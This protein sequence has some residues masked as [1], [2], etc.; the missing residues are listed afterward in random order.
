MG[1]RRPHPAGQRTAAPDIKTF[2]ANEEPMSSRNKSG[3]TI[4][5]AKLHR[6]RVTRDL[7][8][9]PRLLALLDAGRT[10]PLTVVVAPA[11]FGKSTLVSSWIAELVEGRRQGINL[12][13]AIWLSL[14]E[15][16]S[17]PTIFLRYFISGLRTIFPGAA[18]KTLKLLT[19]S[20][21]PHSLLA[22]TLSNEI[23]SLPSSFFIILDDAHTL[24]SP[25]V[26]DILSIWLQHWP[27]HMHLVL[28]SRLNP[29]LPLTT[30]RA[31]DQVVEIRPRDLRFTA[32]ETAEYL[33]QTL[34]SSVDESAL[35]AIHQ[36]MEGWIT[37]LKLATFSPDMQDNFAG[38]PQAVI[39]GDV[40]I[41]D[42]LIEEVLLQQPAAIQRFLLTISINRQF[43]ESLCAALLGDQDP[44][45]DVSE[46]LAYLEANE[47]FL[48]DMDNRREWYRLHQM[49][50]DLLRRKLQYEMGEKALAELHSRAARWY[51]AHD[52]LDQA[53]YHALKGQD[54]VLA[55]QIMQ[56]GICDVLNETDRPKLER[57]LHMLP[58]EIIAQQP[59]LMVM[60]GWDHALRWEMALA[61][62]AAEQAETLLDVSE[63]PNQTDNEA[64]WRGQ[65]AVLKSQAAY[66][67][68]QPQRAAALCR[69]TLA[70]MPE[71]WHYVRGAAAIFLGVSLYS[72]GHMDEAK[73]FLTTQYEAQP[74]KSNGYALRL[75][76][77]LVLNALQAG[78]FETAQRTAQVML[79]Q[80]IQ[81]GETL[82]QGWAHYL[83]GTIYYHW[84]DLEAAER[85]S[86]A[87]VDM[88][89][90]TQ[91]LVARSGTIGLALVYQ[92]QGKNA[93]ALAVVD[94]LAN[95]E[96][97]LYGREKTSTTAARARLLFL[98]GDLDGADQW[99]E[100]ITLPPRDQ[101]LLPWMDWL[102]LTRVAVLIARRSPADIKTA[103]Q[104]LDALD[105]IALRTHSTRS[106]VEILALRALALMAQG[107]V[108]AA[109]KNLINSIKLARRSQQIRVYLDLGLPMQKLLVQIAGQ[110]KMAKTVRKILDAF[111]EAGV[112][113]A[114]VPP[115]LTPTAHIGSGLKTVDHELSE[116]LTT[117]ELE[118]LTLMAEPISLAEISDQLH[119]AHST[120][121]RH[122]INLYEKLGVHSRWEAVAAAVEYGILSPR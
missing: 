4:L 74:D 117:R 98:Q 32:A 9:R 23:E 89:Y 108:V 61:L 105:E 46:S 75:L 29:A 109:R 92:A 94:D 115:A 45:L 106:R 113:G 66:F 25:A 121:K 51:A 22:N 50:R 60:C 43:N 28:V 70:L 86:A 10:R 97:E 59:E 6:P 55:T 3:I 96:L 85:H 90:T 7:I 82:S 2:S 88:R 101:P 42:Y 12:L 41:T 38:R 37:G 56:A 21:P 24:H 14:D 44:A 107:D 68:N 104:A 62:Q 95:F 13:P 79:R 17:D 40:H 67:N 100:Q 35:A 58:P 36:Q 65:I 77:T 54:L 99:S 81:N 26:F 120:A 18:P 63:G 69:T 34:G 87:T 71:N 119:I 110:R 83:L 20:D 111:A 57:W 118:V 33:A 52:L 15:G 102:L 64:V 73:R 48:I 78:Q 93:A 47:L 1:S 39:E 11:G 53:L 5:N 31:K 49:F 76:Q 72:G 84:N 91:L 114:A 122:S 8:I 30:L 116:Q 103:H 19:A 80:S 27:Q 112:A 16:D